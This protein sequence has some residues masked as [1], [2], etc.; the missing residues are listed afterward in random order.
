MLSAIRRPATNPRLLGWT[1]DCAT[2]SRVRLTALATIFWQELE[3]DFGLQ[4]LMR[5][6]KRSWEDFGVKTKRDELN[7]SGTAAPASLERSALHK[8]NGA[9][10]TTLRP[11]NIR[12]AVGPWRRVS[13]VSRSRID[14]GV[15]KRLDDEIR[16]HKVGVAEQTIDRAKRA[17]LAGHETHGTMVGR[18]SCRAICADRR[19]CVG[20]QHSHT[21]YAGGR[22]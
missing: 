18:Q 10:V 2:S 16:R 3:R 6:A 1:M 9:S 13:G 4:G 22:A 15:H 17:G 19:G 14:L 11:C 12:D 21:M 5:L 8:S 7:H 20:M